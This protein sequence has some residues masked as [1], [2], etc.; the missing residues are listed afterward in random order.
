MC[1]WCNLLLGL[2]N[3]FQDKEM[4]LCM[5]INIEQIDKQQN[6]PTVDDLTEQDHDI[7]D[8]RVYTSREYERLPAE[9]KTFEDYI[10]T[11]SDQNK[12][13]SN[14]NNLLSF[15]GSNDLYGFGQ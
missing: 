15:F 7:L 14:H 5:M 3:A 4:Q 13:M 12:Q 1:E 2:C 11:R 10:E 8:P 6:I 9:E